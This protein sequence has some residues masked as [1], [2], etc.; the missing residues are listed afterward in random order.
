VY[1]SVRD[2]IHAIDIDSIDYPDRDPDL[3][4]SISHP[5]FI[6]SF[7]VFNQTVP[8]RL[9]DAD[10]NEIEEIEARLPMLHRFHLASNPRGL[11]SRHCRHLFELSLYVDAT[12]PLWLPPEALRHLV[13]PTLKSLSLGKPIVDLGKAGKHLHNLLPNLDKILWE[14]VH[15]TYYDE[16]FSGRRL[17][18]GVKTTALETRRRTSS[19]IVP[20]API[21]LKTILPE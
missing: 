4:K 16:D 6:I 14:T 19:L 3:E 21:K 5:P 20:M 10:D 13:H 9:L 7:R 18:A 8:L 11:I 17:R 15:E 12:L 1:F 2:L